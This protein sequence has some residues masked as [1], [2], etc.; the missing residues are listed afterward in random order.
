[1]TLA[2]MRCAHGHDAPD[3]KHHDDVR[4]SETIGVP[5]RLAMDSRGGHPCAAGLIRVVWTGGRKVYMAACASA[6]PLRENT[7]ACVLALLANVARCP[8][9]DLMARYAG[10]AVAYCLLGV[11]AR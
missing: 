9:R 8:C 1:M 4:R 2:M 7:Y 11:E 3:N 6:S 10:V 5:L